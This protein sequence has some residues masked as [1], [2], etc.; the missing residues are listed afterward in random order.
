M[1]QHHKLILDTVNMSGKN[2]TSSRHGNWLLAEVESHLHQHL[3]QSSRELKAA[4]V[5]KTFTY[6]GL[7]GRALFGSGVRM[8][9]LAAALVRTSRRRCCCWPQRNC[10]MNT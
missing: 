9:A 2:C 7:R 3:A 5:N 10:M 1:Q 4:C 8:R 6:L